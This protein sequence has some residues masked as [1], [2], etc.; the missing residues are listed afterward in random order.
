LRYVVPISSQALRTENY[1]RQPVMTTSK[2]WAVV[3]VVVVA[4]MAGAA[5]IMRGRSEDPRSNQQPSV[6][7]G[8]VET[9]TLTI[10]GMI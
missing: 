4:L 6:T 8:T 1:N 7:Q 3:G 10:H 9:V 2:R 5:M